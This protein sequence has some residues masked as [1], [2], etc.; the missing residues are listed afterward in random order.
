MGSDPRAPGSGEFDLC[1]LCV[2][3]V[4]SGAG[5]VWRVTSGA[6]VV[7]LSLGRF[8]VVRDTNFL[9]RD[10]RIS[11]LGCWV[12]ATEPPARQTGYGL[13]SAPP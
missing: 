11:L 8:L 5:V 1:F 10:V 4:T 13:C 12:A 2:W 9:G 7:C 3:R 6:C